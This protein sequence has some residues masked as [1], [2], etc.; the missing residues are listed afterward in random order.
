MTD[1]ELKSLVESN[2]KAIQALADQKLELER[3]LC[4]AMLMCANAQAMIARCYDQEYT[5]RN[6]N[7]AINRD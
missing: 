5:D 1:E 2:A 4:T 6:S 7:G 3:I